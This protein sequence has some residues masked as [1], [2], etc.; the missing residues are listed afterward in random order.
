MNINPP[1]SIDL[2]A[3]K[4]AIDEAES[5]DELL[6]V[7]IKI[8]RAIGWLHDYAHT[9]TG[10]YSNNCTSEYF[11]RLRTLLDKI[12]TKKKAANAALTTPTPP[13]RNNR[14]RAKLRARFMLYSAAVVQPQYADEN[15]FRHRQHHQTRMVCD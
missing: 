1:P 8:N 3:F 14:R 15:I 6:V 7:E 13:P 11:N 10:K 4:K 9:F 2:I 5:Y 12:D